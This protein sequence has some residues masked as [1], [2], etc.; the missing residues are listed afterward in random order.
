MTPYQRGL[1]GPPYIP[2]LVI[3]L[4]LPILFFH[5]IITIGEVVSVDS[6]LVCLLLLKHKLFEDKAML[7]LIAIC[8]T[9]GGTYTEYVLSEYLL[10]QLMNK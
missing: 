2:Y 10:N 8:I 4:L 5:S 9:Q 6:L 1:L 7:L 3:F